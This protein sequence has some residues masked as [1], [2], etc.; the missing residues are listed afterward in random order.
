MI[1]F[2]YSG[3]AKLDHG[4]SLTN[5]INFTHYERQSDKIQCR[6]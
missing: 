3:P 6:L 5:L 2:D 1:D 4:L